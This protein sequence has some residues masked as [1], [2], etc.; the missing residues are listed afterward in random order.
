MPTSTLRLLSAVFCGLLAQGALAAGEWETRGTTSRQDIFAFYAASTEEIFAVGQGGYFLY[1]SNSGDVWLPL[2]SP[3]KESLFSIWGHKDSLYL[4]GQSGTLLLSPNKGKD[5][6]PLSVETKGALRGIWGS[7]PNDIYVVG[8][9]GTILHSTDGESFTPQRSNV[10]VALYSIW[11]SGP[12]DIFVVGEQGT[13]LRSTDQGQTWNKLNSGSTEILRGVYGLSDMEVFVVGYQRTILHS[14]DHG[15]SWTQR[16][17][18]GEEWFSSMTGTPEGELYVVG[19][20]GL[21]LRSKDKGLSWIEEK[22]DTLNPLYAVWG[23]VSRQI[24]IGGKAGTIIAQKLPKPVLVFTDGGNADSA[25]IY[26]DGEKI[27]QVPKLEQLKPGRY[28]IEIKRPLFE[29][30]SQWVTIQNGDTLNVP[31]SLS[32]VK[33]VTVFVEG[34][35]GAEIEIDGERRGIAPL[36]QKITPGN[37]TLSARLPDFLDY[38]ETFAAVDEDI[39]LSPRL[40]PIPIIKSP[41]LKPRALLLGSGAVLGLSLVPTSMGVYH[42]IRADQKL[43]ADFGEVN[44]DP[45]GTLA[46]YQRHRARAILFGAVADSMWVVSIG[47]VIGA[48]VLNQKLKEEQK[49]PP[50]KKVQLQISPT[51][52]SLQLKF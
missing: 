39:F 10:S 46:E 3:T 36:T 43:Q 27:G 32:P 49:A 47:G 20:K 40:E 18:P 21:V 34:P 38:S 45:T 2:K 41:T 16:L 8:D 35:A 51:G 5:W 26:I 11:G 17:S 30:Y 33:T 1:S 50:E 48:Y 29:S 44:G 7:G 13:I 24:R 22:N 31:I 28:F 37:H 52:A 6:K 14:Q 4:A 9:Q 19:A 42:L 12:D 15:T 25:D 23:G